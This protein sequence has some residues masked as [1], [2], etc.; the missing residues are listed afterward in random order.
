[1]RCPNGIPHGRRPQEPWVILATEVR[2]EI[3]DKVG[4]FCRDMTYFVDGSHAL[5]I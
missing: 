3:L 4:R 2:S 1:M 5:H